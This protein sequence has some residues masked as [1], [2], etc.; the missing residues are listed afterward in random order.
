[1]PARD[2]AIFLICVRERSCICAGSWARNGSSIGTTSRPAL[3]A[4]S[5]SMKRT[6]D[7][8][9]KILIHGIDCVAAIGVTS[10]ERTIK[11]RLSIDIEIL[12]DAARAAQN[13]SLKETID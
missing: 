1:M 8:V 3:Q 9:D 5:R 12:V 2:S 13:D 11:Q 6:G 10:E 4:G 7:L